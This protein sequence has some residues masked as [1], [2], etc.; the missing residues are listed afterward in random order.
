[1]VK[2]V[3]MVGKSKRLPGKHFIEVLP[4]K[5]LI[6]IVVNN[7]QKTNMEVFIYSKIPFKINVPLIMDEQ[8]W[9][10]PSVINLIKEID[11]DLFIFGGDMPFIS[12]FAI[13]KILENA[14]NKNAVIPRWKNGF[15]E[16]LRSFYRKEIVGCLETALNK[17]KGSL[18]EAIFE[19][20]NVK[21]IPAEELPEETFF[22]VNTY[23]DLKKMREIL[24][25]G[26]RDGI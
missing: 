22:N 9:I 15:V 5:R 1:M 23:N 13:K 10:L 6:D 3:L 25:G 20:D 21:Y 16:P 7:L 18:H 11:D 8:S 2:I 24:A 14:E 4:G 12:R 26:V 17:K 19:C